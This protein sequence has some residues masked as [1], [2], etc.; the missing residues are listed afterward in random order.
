MLQI[1]PDRFISDEPEAPD[2]DR[3]RL[4]RQLSIDAAILDLA[5]PRAFMWNH[6]QEANHW[7]ESRV[8]KNLKVCLWYLFRAFEYFV[9]YLCLP[10]VAQNCA[11]ILQ[12]LRLIGEQMYK[13]VTE[14]RFLFQVECTSISCEI[15]KLLGGAACRELKRDMLM[16]RSF[17]NPVVAVSRLEH[18]RKI[19][20][21]SEFEVVRVALIGTALLVIMRC[22]YAELVRFKRQPEYQMLPIF[23]LPLLL[24][25]LPQ[26]LA[27]FR[28]RWLNHN[29]RLPRLMIGFSCI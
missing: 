24:Q 29:P 20:C 25:E 27:Q 2:S 12:I 7:R 19:L 13:S 1:E 11:S 22:L 14:I 3:V 5:R 8:D 21:C 26:A 28:R 4:Q 16:H 23:Q 10:I 17:T 18:I 6:G 15:A 9:G